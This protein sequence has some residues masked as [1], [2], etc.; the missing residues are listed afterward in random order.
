[1]KVAFKMI[2]TDQAM[3]IRILRSAGFFGAL[4]FMNGL[5]QNANEWA[6]T[7]GFSLFGMLTGDTSKSGIPNG[8]P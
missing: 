5:P 1:M 2:W 4:V 8:K 6:A 7:V 3:F